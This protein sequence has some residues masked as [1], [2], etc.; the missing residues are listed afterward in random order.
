[1]GGL[2][3]LMNDHLEKLQEEYEIHFVG[4]VGS[5]G[6]KKEPFAK[7]DEEWKYGYQNIDCIYYH[8]VE[9]TEDE[10]KKGNCSFQN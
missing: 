5:D 9:F 7:N 1:V 3:S 10:F 2:T 8:I 4:W 6:S